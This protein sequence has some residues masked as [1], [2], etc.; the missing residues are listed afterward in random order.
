M[1]QQNS[2]ATPKRSKSLLKKE[3]RP[4]R[5]D[6]SL[7]ADLLSVASQASQTTPDYAQ[8]VHERAETVTTLLSAI[9]ERPTTVRR[10][11]H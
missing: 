8:E 3:S 10:W 11:R 1:T 4:V 2:N 6:V 9:L 7:T 5:T